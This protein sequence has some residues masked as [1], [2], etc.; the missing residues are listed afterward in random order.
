MEDA[1]GIVEGSKE[2]RFF[3]EE[4]IEKSIANFGFKIFGL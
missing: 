2:D 3:C 1:L 4:D